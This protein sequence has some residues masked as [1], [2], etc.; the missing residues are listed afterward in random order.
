[1][2][3]DQVHA[4]RLAIMCDGTSREPTARD[5]A[6]A[7]CERRELIMRGAKCLCGLH[8][9]IKYERQT[10]LALGGV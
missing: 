6:I 9:A 3:P 1:M 4:E 2:T 10:R 8:N 7:N 5:Y